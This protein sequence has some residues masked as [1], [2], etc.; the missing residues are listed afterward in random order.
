VQPGHSYAIG[1]VD[2][3]WT[4]Q[5]LMGILTRVGEQ[6]EGLDLRLIR[7]TR[8]HGRVATPFRDSTYVIIRQ[9]GAELPPDLQRS[10]A[11]KER[12][13]LSYLTKLDAQGRYE[14]H[15]SPGDYEIYISDLG[16]TVDRPARKWRDMSMARASSFAILSGSLHRRRS[17][18]PGSLS[19]PCQAAR[20]GQSKH[21]SR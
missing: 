20:S 18:C 2:P 5:P 10:L 9:L 11:A 21:I 14:A 15:L 6:R 17:A 13:G 1:V 12:Q 8:L 16:R 4:A 19:E 7:G 3:D